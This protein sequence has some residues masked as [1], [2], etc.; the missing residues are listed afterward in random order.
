MR[1]NNRNN[2]FAA[3]AVAAGLDPKKCYFSLSS[4]EVQTVD[5]IRKMFGYS[6]YNYMGRSRCRQ[7]WYAI[8][9]GA[10]I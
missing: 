5:Q 9:K 6:G 10:N 7:F 4:D 3:A 2:E 8:Q 1:R